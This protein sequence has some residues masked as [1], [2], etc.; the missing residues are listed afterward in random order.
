MYFAFSGV[1]S[2]RDSPFLWSSAG[3]LAIKFDDF[4]LFMSR[5][6]TWMTSL[7]FDRLWQELVEVL[8]INVVCFQLDLA[9]L[10]FE[11]IWGLSY[12]MSPSEREN[13]HQ[14]S[15]RYKYYCEMMFPTSSAQGSGFN[16]CGAIDNIRVPLWVSG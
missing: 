13:F 1:R 3:C 2:S 9:S 11:S 12:F 8:D 6:Y 10:L 5:L 4:W 15:E 14:N 16:F 7:H